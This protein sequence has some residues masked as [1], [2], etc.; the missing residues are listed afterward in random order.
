MVA[1][2]TLCGL[3]VP[4]DFVS[5]FGI[6]AGRAPP[7]APRPPAMT[8]GAFRMPASTEPVRTAEHAPDTGCAMV[9]ARQVHPAADSS[10]QP[11]C[12]C[13]WPKAL[14]SPC[15]RR[16]PPLWPTGSPTTT[17]AEKLRFLPPLTTLVTR[18]MDT[19]CS[20]RL[21]VC[22]VDALHYLSASHSKLELQSCFARRVGQSLHAAM[23]LRYPP[24]SKTTRSNALFLGAL[25]DAACQPLW[26]RPRCLPL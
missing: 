10:W 12:P 19:T 18:L 25:R 16:S 9:V 24:R 17:K 1:F 5:T 15:R 26:R 11:R 22:R 8:P 14:P 20:F 6:P 3:C 2:T 7:P 21:S 13:G 23:I 4:I